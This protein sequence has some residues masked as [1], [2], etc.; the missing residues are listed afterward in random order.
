M[1]KD[2]K[3][4]I[5]GVFDWFLAGDFSSLVLRKNEAFDENPVVLIGFWQ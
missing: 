1:V 4:V 2:V 3:D 5:N